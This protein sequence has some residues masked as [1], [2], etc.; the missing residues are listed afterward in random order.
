M[1]SEAKDGRPVTPAS[2]SQDTV[3]LN[4]REEQAG[5]IR[6]SFRTSCSFNDRDWQSEEIKAF[7]QANFAEFEQRMN[8]TIEVKV[9]EKVRSLT[10]YELNARENARPGA[11]NNP[12]VW[13]INA[14]SLMCWKGWDW[15]H[16][17][18]WNNETKRFER[19]TNSDGSDGKRG[20]Q[21]LTE[22]Y[23]LRYFLCYFPIILAFFEVNTLVGMTDQG[24]TIKRMIYGDSYY[25]SALWRYS[26]S[27]KQRDTFKSMESSNGTKLGMTAKILRKRPANEASRCMDS[28]LMATNAFEW[29]SDTEKSETAFW[30]IAE[31]VMPNATWLFAHCVPWEYA[32]LCANVLRANAALNDVKRENSLPR[33]NPA[34][35][36]LPDPNAHPLMSVELWDSLAASPEEIRQ[37]HADAMV[38]RR[39]EGQ[40]DLALW[41][42][43]R[44]VCDAKSLD[45]YDDSFSSFLYINVNYLYRIGVGEAYMMELMTITT[46]S[47]F[48]FYTSFLAETQQLLQQVT[49]SSAL[50]CYEDIVLPLG[51]LKGSAPCSHALLRK[52]EKKLLRGRL[53]AVM[54]YAALVNSD[55]MSDL[56][57]SLR[58]IFLAYMVMCTEMITTW[59][60]LCQNYSV[61]LI[62]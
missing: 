31:N 34:Q 3:T 22:T 61:Y 52:A 9:E 56:F 12:L 16:N 19:L 30:P 47:F 53:W 8:A 62:D 32:N 41:V 44:Q 25:Q 54:H 7:V 45:F 11:K 20:F 55:L 59:V 10:K 18:G 49:L 38:P 39:L 50:R 5:D 37:S 40:A 14:M 23:I 42:L 57:L 24:S 6:S 1:I 4:E 15:P 33:W 28:D 29:T 2:S 13:N 21:Y 58:I 43:T 48:L 51:N 36:L 35:C 27:A 60:R 17:Q 26:R 46:L